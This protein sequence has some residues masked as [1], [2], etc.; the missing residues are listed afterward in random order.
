MEQDV[1]I[2]RAILLSLG[3]FGLDRLPLV[4]RQH[5]LPRLEQVYRNDPDPGLHSAAEWLLRHWQADGKLKE[6]DKELTTGK[7]EGK[8]RWYINGQGQTMVVVPRPGEF[9]MGDDR[10]G[11]N[12]RHKRRIN[13]TFAIASREV[14]VEQFL[15]FRKVD[16]LVKD[17]APTSN[18]PVNRVNWYEAAAY[19][20]WLSEKEGIPKEQWC[21]EPNEKGEYAEGMKMA[22]NCLQ[23]TGYRLPTDAEWEFACRA[24]ADTTY[25]FGESKELLDKYGWSIG[26]SLG[27]S[28]PA[29][30]LRPNDLGLFDMHGNAWEWCQDIYKEFVKGEDGKARDDIEDTR[31]VK[32]GDTRVLHG[33]S[34]AWLPGNVR[35]AFRLYYF[36][37]QRNLDVGFRPARTFR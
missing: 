17:Y 26:N 10:V 4:E 28:Q 14:T 37:A 2:K 27:K 8:R 15:L 19:C 34:F 20:N 22:A 25:S 35:S 1:S 7:V 12:P 30:A 18:C 33:G 31:D 36:P 6:I 11:I 23:R 9:W 3:E 5:L 16:A 29:G 13:R 24:K 21:Y 32:G